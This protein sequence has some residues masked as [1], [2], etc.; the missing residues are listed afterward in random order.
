MADILLALAV[1]FVIGM[2][3]IQHAEDESGEVKEDF[4]GDD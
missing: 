4:H 2:W 3:Y 1:F